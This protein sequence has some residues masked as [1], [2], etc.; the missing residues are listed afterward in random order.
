MNRGEKQG[1]T[2]LL[3]DKLDEKDALPLRVEDRDD[4]TFL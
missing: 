4:S 1:H 2:D 3:N